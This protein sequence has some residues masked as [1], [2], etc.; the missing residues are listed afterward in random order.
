M[1]L[2]LRFNKNYFFIIT[3]LAIVV[4]VFLLEKNIVIEKR[5]EISTNE[6]GQDKVIISAESSLARV[7]AVEKI[8]NEKINEGQ[9]IP[10]VPVAYVGRGMMSDYGESVLVL[11]ATNGNGICVNILV[12]KLSGAEND[13]QSNEMNIYLYLSG[14]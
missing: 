8:I 11:S 5:S 1:S 12:H 6:D 14:K 7:K 9:P 13:V 10:K 4:C 2:R 3:F